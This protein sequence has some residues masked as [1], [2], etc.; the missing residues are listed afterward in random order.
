MPEPNRNRLR[1][2]VLP[3]LA[4]GPLGND[5]LALSLSQEIGAGLARFRWFDVISPMALMNRPPLAADQRGVLASERARLCDR[6][7]D[8]RRRREVSDQRPP[9]RS[10]EIR[11]PGVERAL[12]AWRR[13]ALP[14]RRG[15]GADR[16]AHRSAHPVHR[17]AAEAARQGRRDQSDHAGDAHDL[18]LGARE[19]RKGRRPH[20]RGASHRA[21]QCHGAR[22]GGA[23]AHVACRPGLDQEC[24]TRAG[25]RRR[26]L[27]QGDPDRSGQCGGAWHLR[28]HLLM[29]EGLRQRAAL[30]RSRAALE[31]RISPSSG[32]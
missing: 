20:Q 12:R 22:L 16:R 6:R 10:D 25:A 26:A 1:V 13:R 30:F 28:A 23:L 19:V 31:S 24:G 11:K 32:R 2:G 14:A 3:F 29:E 9:A 27:P 5:G 7:R 15:G 17:G 8:I 21:R 18:Q 4:T